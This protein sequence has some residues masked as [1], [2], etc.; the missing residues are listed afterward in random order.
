MVV[1]GLALH[2][3]Y[4]EI[5]L[6][7]RQL[8]CLVNLVHLADFGVNLACFHI[9][10]TSFRGTVSRRFLEHPLPVIEVKHILNILL[11]LTFFRDVDVV[12]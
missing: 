7:I 4:C 11:T 1:A 12:Q 5:L 3:S 8:A 9:L 6:C 10:V 2:E